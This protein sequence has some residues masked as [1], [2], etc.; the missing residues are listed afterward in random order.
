MKQALFK[1]YHYSG[2]WSWCS[3]NLWS[4][5][6]YSK[7]LCTLSEDRQPEANTILGS[8]E[9]TLFYNSC[10]LF[11][12]PSAGH[13]PRASLVLGKS[14]TISQFLQL[15]F[16][17]LHLG[18]HKVSELIARPFAQ[19]EKKKKKKTSTWASKTKN[20]TIS[21]ELS[22]LGYFS[23]PVGHKDKSMLLIV[24]WK[25]RV[26]FLTCCGEDPI[27][28]IQTLLTAYK[29]KVTPCQIQI[30]MVTMWL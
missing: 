25:C 2:S 26:I 12:L 9:V 17:E 18:H 11:P 3:G 15:P 24:L 22:C 7:K 21:K 23:Y 29:K 14:S 16:T 30:N 13:G 28:T 20:G 5:N 4:T 19:T 6:N 10:F 27:T 1:N 8:S